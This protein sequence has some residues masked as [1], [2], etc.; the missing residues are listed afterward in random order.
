[1]SLKARLFVSILAVVFTVV[2]ALSALNLNHAI[3]ESFE[4]VDE[5][6]QLIAQQVRT[7]VQEIIHERTA[8]LSLDQKSSEEIKRTWS[9]LVRN[10]PRLSRALET[11]VRNSSF[12]IDIAVVNDDNLVL[13]SSGP[14]GLDAQP[15]N[16]PAFTEWQPKTVL[17]RL[18]DLVT[19]EHH[20]V[21]TLPLLFTDRNDPSLAVKIF[22]S[23]VLLR[24]EILPQVQWLVAV[25]ASFLAISVLLGLLVAQLAGQ[26]VEQISRNIE[27]ISTG[28]VDA[29][30]DGF[31]SK[32]LA[33]LDRKLNQL[34]DRFRLFRDDA[35]ELRSNLDQMLE[36]LE[37]TVLLFGPDGCLRM[38]GRPAERLLAKSRADLIG[39]PME[40]VFPA[41]TELG[42]AIQKAIRD[43]KPL[44]DQPVTL[45]RSNMPPARLVLNV[46]LLDHSTE[47]QVSTLVT[48]RDAD[49]RREL[50]S[51]FDTATRLAAISRIT[52]GLA[53]EIKNPLN[54]I[55]LHLEAAKAK[56]QAGPGGDVGSEMEIIAK[57][58]SRLDRVVKTFLDF[59][60]PLEL[61]MSECDLAELT[62]EIADLLRP[63]AKSRDIEIQLESLI[64]KPIVS[65]DRD[66]LKE[67]I[68]NVVLNGIEAMNKTGKLLLQVHPAFDNYVLSVTD[69]GQGIAPAIQDKIYNLYFTTKESASG[70]G[71]AVTFRVMQIHN[72]T[73]KFDSKVGKGTT[74]RLDL[75]A[76]LKAS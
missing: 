56:L 25:S 52:S 70:I 34:G 12:V 45:Q 49:S 58:V 43:R 20:Y 30:R 53:H 29:V 21:V 67:A 33:A 14:A 16:Q 8:D 73:I 13:A 11:T 3:R 47:K 28:Q 40:Q 42:T 17:E 76:L 31:E 6:A 1:M 60:K 22:V 48:L 59:N 7:F 32:E 18:R 19:S 54:A 44:R 27:R 57:E 24:Q 65:G 55:A 64:D 51:H 74:F 71:L 36:Q 26:S 35:L 4:D 10:D 39:Q 46:E 75:P 63:Q 61:K 50:Q 68:L 15:A 9:A 23:S 2:V 37:E 69:E 72:G 5:R 38:A 41:W 62:R 66:L